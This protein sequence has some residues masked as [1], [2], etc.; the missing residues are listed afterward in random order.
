MKL[1]FP[2]QFDFVS[3]EFEKS[4]IWEPKTTEYVEKHLKEGQTFI[5]VGANV[6]YYSILASKLGAKVLAF[7][8]S[9]N[10]RTLLEKNIKDNECDVQVF[11]QALSN[12]NGSAILYTDTTPG[13]YSLVGSGKGEKVD[14]IKYDDLKLPIGDF[15][16]IDAEV[17]EKNVL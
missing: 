4:G 9:L 17:A 1:T 15:Y 12:V 6:G 11:S 14:C 3:Q 16:K 8:P 5:D 7:E 13:Q 10:N 2:E